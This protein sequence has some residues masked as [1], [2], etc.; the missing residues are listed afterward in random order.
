[1]T[2]KKISGVLLVLTMLVLLISSC[3]KNPIQPNEPQ[4]LP[5]GKLAKMSFKDGSYDSVFYNNDGSIARIINHH[6][7]P[8]PYTEE[9]SYEYDTNGKVKR[10]NQNNG[11]YYQYG[12][13]G[14]ELVA[15]M[16]YV[17][18][19]KRDYKLY[20]Y[21]D[22]KLSSIE[23]YYQFDPNVPG[24][25]LYSRRDYS[26]YQD[27]NLKLEEN[28]SFDAQT[29]VPKK[30]F[31]IEHA[32]YDGKANTSDAVARFLYMSSIEFAKHN[33]RKMKTKDEVS[34]VVTE[35][36]SEYTYD[37]AS[38]PLTRR[39]SYPSGGQTITETILFSYY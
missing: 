26:Y 30:D 5:S 31:T 27:G 11:E 16:H 23:E 19:R 9:F 37:A 17:N 2:Q 13:I 25:E 8:G 35:F 33:P 29:H 7:V 15:V 28:Y 34:G 21:V 38:R 4:P 24:H 1:M 32:D 6:T 36:Q 39:I 10:I 18:G 3:R 20:D 12:F 14:E 22:H